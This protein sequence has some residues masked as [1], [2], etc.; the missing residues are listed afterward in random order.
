MSASES[1]NSERQETYKVF[2]SGDMVRV[3]ASRSLSLKRYR[4]SLSLAAMPLQQR[5]TCSVCRVL[6]NKGLVFHHQVDGSG[7]PHRPYVPFTTTEPSAFDG[8]CP[9]KW[10]WV[11]A[12]YGTN[13]GE[14]W[15][16]RLTTNAPL[17][18]WNAVGLIK[19][20]D[21][22]PAIWTSLK[23]PPILF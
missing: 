7:H 17:R 3:W 9:C 13:C 4:W 11:I 6:K 18:S 10:G 5:W 12:S 16:A 15:S 21:S 19:T 23:S 8:Q 1:R 2:P 20:N 22:S 14:D